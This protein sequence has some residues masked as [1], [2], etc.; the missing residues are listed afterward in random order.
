MARIAD[1]AVYGQ[2][3]GPGA[4]APG[5]IG[6]ED[7]IGVEDVGSGPALDGD[8]AGADGQVLASVPPLPMV[9]E[10][11]AE[12]RKVRLWRAMGLSREVVLRLAAAGVVVLKNTS[13]VE[14]GTAPGEESLTPAFQL[15][16][17]PHLLLAAP[18]Q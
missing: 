16:E 17:V 11:A 9:T 4:D 18:L 5:L 3:G 10:E 7:D 15:P 8:A 14:V 13:A 1:A 12:A 2:S 6:V